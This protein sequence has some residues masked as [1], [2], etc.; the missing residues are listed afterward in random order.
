MTVDIPFENSYVDLPDAFYSRQPPDPVSTPEVL[1]MNIALANDL[2]ITGI[3][4]LDALANIFSGNTLANGSVPLAQVY[5]GHQFGSFNPRLGDGRAILLGEVIDRAGVRQDIMLKGSGRTP[6]SRG[7]DGRAWLGPVLREF[8]I[9]EAMH[10]LGIPTTRALAAVATGDLVYRETPLPG[11]ILTRVA[12]SHLRVGTFQ[13]FAAQRDYANLERLFEYAVARH[14]PDAQNPTSF[15]QKVIERQIALVAQWM[16]I[17]FIHGVMNTDNCHI[18]G[19]TIDYG[20]CAFMDRYRANQVY[21][22]ID[23]FGRY[24]YRAQGN[25]IIWN[26]AQLATSLVPLMP[27]QDDAI[28]AFTTIINAMSDQ[29]NHQWLTVFAAKIGISTP[30]PHDRKLITDLL[31]LMETQGADFT[32]TFFAL[33]SGTAR[34]QFLDRDQ[35]DLWHQ[36]WRARVADDPTA[37]TVMSRANPWIIPRNHQIE[38]MINDA[39]NGDMARFEHLAKG[40]ATPYDV[41]E[42]YPDLSI[43]PRDD[44]EIEATF[45]GT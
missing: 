2:G 31:A 4:N 17:G 35:Y 26:I 39:V 1:A 24:A 29:F 28:N 21:S 10:A 41:D 23:R 19:I 42:T 43:P 13:Y 18:A 5:A 20:P 44:Q 8:I 45:C 12:P 27:N 9:S 40:L 32:N 15:L 33:R 37:D 6:Y 14:Y 16:G 30:R 25:I 36:R 11:A 7:G 3:D 22:S 34:D 38:A